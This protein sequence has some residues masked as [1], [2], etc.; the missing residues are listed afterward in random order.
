MAI[1]LMTAVFK[2]YPEG[3]SERL[4]A[5]AIADAANA[6]GTHVFVGVDTLARMTKQSERSVQRQLHQM[7]ATGWLVLERKSTGRRGDVTHYKI[8]AEWIAGGEPTPPEV[9]PDRRTR[10]KPTGDKVA[11]VKAAEKT[12][13]TGDTQGLSGDTQGLSG[14]TAVSPNPSL[15]FNTQTPQPPAEAGG[16]RGGE[17][18]PG[19]GAG[20]AERDGFAEFWAGYPRKAAEARARRQW[21]MLAPDEALQ[22]R[23]GRAVARQ[24]EAPGW[25]REAGRFVP[26]ASTWLHGER[27]LDGEPE[28]A[29]GCQAERVWDE[30]RGTVE[31]FAARFGMP[32]WD[33]LKEPWPA[34][35]A[36]VRA[37]LDEVAA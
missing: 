21:R 32:A 27:W 7:L 8:S 10:K 18:E 29:D 6:D 12:G 14:D 4:L 13:G 24:K 37:R 2:R 16:A 19:A 9:V 11:P 35:K 3:G 25:Q 33:Q 22:A 28:Q 17:V 15:P 23:I 31:Y 20:S 1:E 5:L 30:S 34:Y 36:R 26:L